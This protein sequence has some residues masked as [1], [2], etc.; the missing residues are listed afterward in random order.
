[1]FKANKRKYYLVEIEKPEGDY[2]IL[3]SLS[4]DSSS[5]RMIYIF[6]PIAGIQTTFKLGRAND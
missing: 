2:L 4:F 3:E 5:S 6:Q 1:V